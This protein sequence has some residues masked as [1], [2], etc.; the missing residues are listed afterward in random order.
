MN[1][2]TVTNTFFTRAAMLLLTIVM[3]IGAWAFDRPMEE[4]T[5][6]CTQGTFS[7]LL[8]G[9]EISY[10]FTFQVNWK[11]SKK[12]GVITEDYTVE[13]AKISTSMPGE[14]SIN[15]NTVTIT[16]N[17]AN[18]LTIAS[19]SLTITST[20]DNS[21]KT[22][23]F[24]VM[25][26]D[27]ESSESNP[28]IISDKDKLKLLA[29]CVNGG[30]TFEGEYLK[31]NTD[32]NYA[33]TEQ[34]TPIGGF[35]NSEAKSFCG[36]FD[37]DGHVISG[38]NINN[39]DNPDDIGIFGRT[40]SGAVVKNLFLKDATITGRQ[41]TGGIV[42]V[43]YGT[44]TNCHVSSSTIN[45]TT[46]GVS[47][48][49]IYHGGIAGNN[50]SGSSIN[51]CTSSATVNNNKDEN[52][53]YASFGAI[54]GG[55]QG[56]LSHNY[57]KYTGLEGC[58]YAD[59]DGAVHATFLSETESV[60]G[61]LSDKDNV[62]FLRSFTNGK[63][64]TIV[65]PFAH[66]PHTL[67]NE[68]SYYTLSK[69]EKNNNGIWEASMTAATSL[70][71]NK[72]YIFVPTMENV[73]F[74]GT[75]DANYATSN[76]SD[77]KEQWTF[78]GTYAEMKWDAKTDSQ[79]RN[80]YGFAGQAVT[81]E[82]DQSKSIEAGEFVRIGEY[83]RL[84]PYRCYLEYQNAATRGSMTEDELPETI[85]VILLKNGGQTNIGSLSTK[86]GIITF[87]ADAWYSLDGKRLN[88]QPARKGIYVNNGKKVVI[89]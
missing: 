79:P 22:V 33:N 80:V 20:Y 67:A 61:S 45:Y 1:R 4:A 26:V 68:G 15:G 13:P 54:V 62:V 40:G 78:K 31:L 37:G 43:N 58:N 55:N 48:S 50:E 9:E 11:D 73:A 69:V 70:A 60:P 39:T 32:L 36:T 3:S 7:K 83:V 59:V 46:T 16:M 53:K 35:Y 24:S 8:K 42:G 18:L 65:L 82:Q 49:P 57:Y 75:A 2:K 89:M 74:I 5:I 23:Y 52:N 86:T 38:V 84:S 44:I 63:N 72:P 19:Y 28:Y 30:I 27:R 17:D 66:T 10:N 88:T 21:K 71:A 81:N 76:L 87:D 77:T 64:S 34:F 85:R 6:E 25:R 14:I 41:N 47:P 12:V 29:D 56:T 51:Y